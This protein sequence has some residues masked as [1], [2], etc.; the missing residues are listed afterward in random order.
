MAL[1]M[2]DMLN[3]CMKPHALMHVLEGLGL[4]LILSGWFGSAS[5]LLGIFALLAGMLGDMMVQ[6]SKKG[7]PSA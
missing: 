1:G 6:K 3:E 7:T 2:R 5:S 4:G